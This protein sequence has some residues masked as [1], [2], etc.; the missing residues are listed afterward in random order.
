MGRG[1]AGLVRHCPHP[2][3]SAQYV[4]E[5]YARLHAAEP[6]F[7]CKCGKMFTAR[8]LVA[9]LT[10]QKRCYGKKCRRRRT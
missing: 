1:K 7:A 6:H 4:V 5:K 10:M 9:H 3:C 2:G 8:G